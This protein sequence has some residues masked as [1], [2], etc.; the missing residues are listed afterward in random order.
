MVTEKHKLNVPETMTEVLDVS[1]EEG[2]CDKQ[3]FYCFIISVSQSISHSIPEYF[4]KYVGK[5]EVFTCNMLTDFQLCIL[6]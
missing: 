5:S 4:L 3:L 6:L 1:D 2:E